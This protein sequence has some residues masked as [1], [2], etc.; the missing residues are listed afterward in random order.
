MLEIHKIGGNNCPI[1]VCDMCGEKLDEASK[2]AAVFENFT[3]EGSK[4]RLLHVHKGSID[5]RTCHAEAEALLAKNGGAVG[6]QEMKAFLAD[7]AANA[8]FPGAE[9]AEYDQ[10]HQDFR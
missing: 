9:M 5:G 8:G 6:W 2:A 3:P 10:R 4:L 1:I 7:L